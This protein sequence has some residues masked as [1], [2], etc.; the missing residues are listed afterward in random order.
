MK[1]LK[2]RSQAVRLAMFLSCMTLVMNLNILNA[3][4]EPILQ[5]IIAERYNEHGSEIDLR[6]YEIKYLFMD[7]V[8]IENNLY[9]IIEMPVVMPMLLEEIPQV[10]EFEIFEMPKLIAVIFPEIGAFNEVYRHIH[11]DE[12]QLRLPIGM[13]FSVIDV[14][15]GASWDMIRMG[16]VNHADTVTRTRND[17]DIM[18]DVWGDTWSWEHRAVIIDT[19]SG[20]RMAASMNGMPHGEYFVNWNENG[21]QGHVCVHFF[22]SKTHIHNSE[23]PQAQEQV[24]IA[25]EFLKLNQI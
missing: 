19:A 25:E 1:N 7:E 21:L 22:G 3:Y 15:T 12:A 17:T 10:S 14:A 20:V 11:W 8:H 23:Q 13:S 24:I 5:E 18:L 16:G 9:Y 6:E 2:L 4:L